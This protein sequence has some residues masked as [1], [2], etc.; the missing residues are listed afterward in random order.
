[1]FCALLYCACAEG[2][3]L[4]AQLGSRIDNGNVPNLCCISE[5]LPREHL[6]SNKNAVLWD[7]A[8]WG[9]VRTDISE[10]RVASITR[11]TKQTS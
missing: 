3:L 8:L 7:V 2:A 10:E 11:V 6:Y 5:R 9:L 4:Q 1:M